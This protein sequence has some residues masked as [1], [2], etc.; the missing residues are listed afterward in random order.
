MFHSTSQTIPCLLAFAVFGHQAA[1][2]TT[3]GYDCIRSAFH[4]ES[5][6]TFRMCGTARHGQEYSC[7]IQ[8]GIWVLL[9]IICAFIF[10]LTIPDWDL[11]GEVLDSGIKIAFAWGWVGCAVVLMAFHSLFPTPLVEER[12]EHTSSEHGIELLSIYLLFNMTEDVE[13]YTDDETF[14]KEDFYRMI[15]ASLFIL[16]SVALGIAH[17]LVGG[18]K[19]L[20]IFA[21]VMTI[22]TALYSSYVIVSHRS[23]QSDLSRHLVLTLSWLFAIAW[24]YITPRVGAL[25]IE[26][27]G[28]DGT[29]LTIFLVV[30]FYFLLVVVAQSTKRNRKWRPWL[31]RAG[32]GY[33]SCM[34]AVTIVYAFALQWRFGLLLFILFLHCALCY[35]LRDGTNHVGVGLMVLGYI[36][37]SLVIFLLGYTLQ[38]KE[39]AAPLAAMEE[40]GTGLTPYPLCNKLHGG[41]DM[42]I[43]DFSLF[44]NLAHAQSGSRA[45]TED[46]RDWFP[47]FTMESEKNFSGQVALR[48]FTSASQNT[49]VVSIRG[50]TDLSFALKSTS[51]WVEVIALYPFE[52]ILPLNWTTQLVYHT[53]FLGRLLHFPTVHES[54]VAEVRRIVHNNST[55][56]K[57]HQ[58]RGVFITGYGYGGWLAQIVG[59]RLGIPTFAFASPGV[60]YSLEKF[61]LSWYSVVRNVVNIVPVHNAMARTDM[62]GGAVQPIACASTASSSESC[63]SLLE[64]TC[65]LLRS[66][67]SAGNRS[68]AACR[69]GRK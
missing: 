37:L 65:E 64:L 16:C 42:S 49:T 36:S 5:V 41:A 68:L 23:M 66:C 11:G 33:L 7:Y 60:Q 40:V 62:H 27:G 4:G 9:L 26:I 55:E 25:S 18:S 46:L 10:F 56:S 63:A 52:L 54:V 58:R 44:C 50:A 20:L 3:R 24:I 35:T 2:V 43:T 8:T 34:V 39:H 67:G 48:V 1:L 59:S 32:Y 15:V 29:V 21:S 47:T 38:V 31:L 6:L 69:I 45:L 61:D 14:K 17:M 13:D 19:V 51:A 30:L 12:Q 53:S 28:L 22:L 57:H